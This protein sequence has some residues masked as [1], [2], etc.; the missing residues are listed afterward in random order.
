VDQEEAALSTTNDP[1]QWRNRAREARA[2]AERMADPEARRQLIEIAATYEQLARL[3]D[4]K[5]LHS[6]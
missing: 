6:T 4:G 2:E 3:A 1:E 5:K